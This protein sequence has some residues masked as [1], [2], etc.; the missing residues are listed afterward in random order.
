MW[1]RLLGNE[2]H[3]PQYGDPGKRKNGSVQDSSQLPR[4]FHSNADECQFQ[5]ERDGYLRVR[6][7]RILDKRV[8]NR[9]CGGII[10]PFCCQTSGY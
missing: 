10:L 2:S 8:R 9:L 7:A 5:A 6:S 4:A 3:G 1:G